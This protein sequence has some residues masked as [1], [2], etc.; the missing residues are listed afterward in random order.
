[1]FPA[2][3]AGELKEDSHQ[4][5]DHSKQDGL[6][7][8]ANAKPSALKWTADKRLT[9]RNDHFVRDTNKENVR[10]FNLTMN[11]NLGVKSD[12]IIGS[13]HRGL[14]RIKWNP[15]QAVFTDHRD[16]KGFRDLSETKSTFD[17]DKIK[18]E[19]KD[20]Y[21]VLKNEFIRESL[22]QTH[23]K[24]LNISN[25]FIKNKNLLVAGVN[26]NYL[27]QTNGLEVSQ[28]KERSVTKRNPESRNFSISSS[29][30]TS[31]HFDF[32]DAADTNYSARF[33]SKTVWPVELVKHCPKSYTPADHESWKFKVQNYKIKTIEEGCGS[34]QNRLITFNDS[35]KAC[36]R[37]RLNSDLMQGEIYS[38]YL[39]KLLKMGYTTPTTL[40]KVDYTDA[41]WSE[42]L[43]EIYNAKWSEIKPLI[44]T[45][46]VEG[47]EPVFMPAELRN[48]DVGI[49][50]N[51]D[52]LKGK[53][54]SELCDLVQWS[55]LIVFDYMAANLDRVVNN[56]FNLKWNDKMMD[57]PIH[58][59]EKSGE[60]G[61]FVFLDNESGLFHGYRLLDSHDQFHKKLLQAVCV[62]KYETVEIIEKLYKDGNIG[63]RLK[64]LFV[65]GEKYQNMLPRISSKSL[66]ILERRLEDVYKH[67][68][69][70]KQSQSVTTEKQEHDTHIKSTAK[71]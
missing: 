45:K 44:F 17:T 34:M 6:N 15:S 7:G 4:L 56:M 33:I 9:S 5:S 38:Y 61:A 14:N 41:Q 57:K 2:N 30:I 46:W 16:L 25:I 27:P 58:N 3:E 13:A 63:S 10:L 11:I 48:L 43:N 29:K 24:L 66:N 62:F 35:T 49:N 31:S 69:T 39:S 12:S 65:S 52:L 70:C 8:R 50:A 22:K 21:R 60:N 28:A 19:Y 42:V 67:M 53:T 71:S 59:L 23:E 55:D 1:M 40:H 37:Y 20:R 51:H 36:V 26:K 54:V 32:S 18:G 47:L 64:D 68:Q